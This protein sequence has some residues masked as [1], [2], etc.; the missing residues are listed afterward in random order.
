MRWWFLKSVK[1]GVRG[2]IT[3]HVDFINNVNL[4]TGLVGSVV[5]FLTEAAYIINTG[6]TGGINFYDI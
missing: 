6:I 2:T 5:H 3:K 1:Q 4:V